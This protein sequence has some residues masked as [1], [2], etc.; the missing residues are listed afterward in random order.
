MTV[1][2]PLG[3][4]LFIEGD[5]VPVISAQV[6]I[7]INSPSSASIQVIPL[8]EVLDLRP[9]TMVHLFFL[10]ADAAIVKNTT[11]GASATSSTNRNTYR[12]LFAGETVGFSWAQSPQSR[13]VVLQCLDFSNYWDSAH[14]SAIEY[15]PGGNPF[16]D[17]GTITA[18]NPGVFD[19]LV[20]QQPNK[21][22]E[23][24]KQQPLTPGL[25][26][27]TGL[28]GGIIRMLEAISGIA[29]KHAGVND[30]FTFAELRC[31][32]LS[33]IT[34][35]ENDKTA[36]NL[37]SNQVMDQWIMSGLQNMGRTVTFRQM[38]NL[39]F[40]YIY[41]EAVSN[42]AAKFDYAVLGKKTTTESGSYA[43]QALPAGIQAVSA[44]ESA[45]DRLTF[46]FEIPDVNFKQET[47]QR[48]TATLYDLNI[49]KKAM[50]TVSATKAEL[51]TDVVSIQNMIGQAISGV[52]SKI[53]SISALPQ[54][55]GISEKNKDIL[56]PQRDYIQGI[57]D[58]IKGT[59]GKFKTYTTS[60][61]SHTQRLRSHIIRPDC[62]FSPP[63]RCNVIFPEHF[64]QISFDRNLIGD[65]TR[66]QVQFGLKL[67][68]PDEILDNYVLFPTAAMSAQVMHYKNE[69]GYRVLM[70]HEVHV[71][72]IPRSEWLPD[73][74]VVNASGQK[75][76]DAKK[77]EVSWASRAGLFNFF[78]Y[79]FAPR[80][81]QVAMR[82]NPF[83]VCGFPALLLRQ[84]YIVPEWTKSPDLP[85][86]AVLNDIHENATARHAPMH[87]V[88]MV[89]SLNHVLDQNGGTTSV[90]MHSVRRHQGIDDDF[91][92]LF[93]NEP[94]LQTVKTQI[95]FADAQ[96]NSDLMKLLI[97][98]TP[99]VSA[100]TA[101]KKKTSTQRRSKPVTVKSSK[102]S[103]D[104]KNRSTGSSTSETTRSTTVEEQVEQPL[105]IGNGGFYTAADLDNPFVVLGD[106]PD[107]AGQ[108]LVPSTNGEI[109][110][111]SKN[112]K[113]A[114]KK[115]TVVGVEVVNGKTE[116]VG[117]KRVFREVIIYERYEVGLQRKRPIEEVLR[118][119]WFS[120][121]YA[122]PSIGPK[123]YMPFF[124]CGS[125]IDDLKIQGL[126]TTPV[127]NDIDPSMGPFSVKAD[128]P[129]DKAAEDI[130]SALSNANDASTE[131]AVNILAFIYGRVK[132]NGFD[133]DSFVRSYI[134]R[135]IATK[136]EILGTEGLEVQV[137]NGEIQVVG[138]GSLG[139]HT[140]AIHRSLF[141]KDKPLNGLLK[142]P[143]IHMNRIGGLGKDSAFNAR[144][145]RQEK[146]DR[147]K[148]YVDRLN[149][150]RA[151]K[152]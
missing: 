133:I 147:V 135:P 151:F 44:L 88:G 37:I 82:F 124:G 39:L 139:F 65:V 60:T 7:G 66:S 22:V 116:L 126:L 18:G 123:I 112:G 95:S 4:R 138:Q 94:L 137:S 148:S 146:W 91:L 83:M 143:D 149:S 109:H 107:V 97:G 93:K 67:I 14:A 15:G 125:V 10:D 131:K 142:D 113:F 114:K 11:Q 92:D 86:V 26:S 96:A 74:H 78:K 20:D 9:R 98:C 121:S 150:T 1:A 29:G 56:K 59:E 32:I 23:W 41:Y 111:N 13:S 80:Q 136:D 84:A 105:L 43:L 99:Q 42:P 24:L 48:A 72:I 8:D 36:S 47:T 12:L 118:P 129:V 85:T 55:N 34:A 61:S 71:G 115:A 2:K 38:M 31:R 6:S 152:G 73:T 62:W 100:S 57:V 128:T 102:K 53:K 49:A 19:D 70:P 45:L 141:A 51:K 132:E 54:T 145:V 25:T 117:T 33:Q 46:S 58:K 87:F 90:L 68:G 110:P 127:T 101:A 5:E 103:V 130:L 120:P 122:N 119:P 134:D 104:P 106:I 63:P 50:D 79:R 76:A 16:H 64:T 17:A 75:G 140:A 52:N 35:E 21:I 27:V 69:G 144:D 89:G 40:Q 3:L 28:A 81:M 30:F 108:R 77:N